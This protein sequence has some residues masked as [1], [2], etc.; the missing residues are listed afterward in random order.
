MAKTATYTCRKCQAEFPSRAEANKHYSDKWHQ[1]NLMR[2]LK[3]LSPISHEE[4]QKLMNKSSFLQEAKNCMNTIACQA[5][6]KSFTSQGSFE[7]HQRSRKHKQNVIRKATEQVRRLKI[8]K[9]KEAQRAVA[10]AGPS[11][12]EEKTG[13]DDASEE[14]EE[15]EEK[16]LTGT[17]SVSEESQY[18]TVCKVAFA[19]EK[20]FKNHAETLKHQNS[21][22]LAQLSQERKEELDK[23]DE[24][25]TTQ[26]DDMEVEEVDSDE[27]DEDDDAMEEE[28][29]DK[30]SL[31]LSV[32]LFC[33]KRSAN[34]ADNLGHMERQH[35][36]IVPHQHAGDLEQLQ[37]HLGEKIGLHHECLEC[38]KPFRSLRA[39][40]LHMLDKPHLAIRFEGEYD[41]FFD[42]SK[43]VADIQL[44]MKPKDNDIFVI[45]LPDGTML[46]HRDLRRYFKQGLSLQSATNNL[47]R[48]HGSGP[49]AITH[50]GKTSTEAKSVM[51]VRKEN[52]RR[53]RHLN[54]QLKIKDKKHLKVAVKANKLQ[55]HLRPQVMNAG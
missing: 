5:C 53:Q 23:Q 4:Y 39:C 31:P 34:L 11:Q 27:W 38:S 42:V 40:R 20:D 9:L 17:V 28:K 37:Q 25:L 30:K 24:L 51:E 18:C 52:R 49:K 45:P 3:E 33:S 50:L 55:P 41:A 2:A 47:K 6:K 21:L 54:I 8:Q 44:P 14:E 36:F 35:S 32:C 29:D 15:V 1:Y 10:A 16:E 48:L 22:K 26:D 46:M 13:E 19:A 7:T 43:I 12:E